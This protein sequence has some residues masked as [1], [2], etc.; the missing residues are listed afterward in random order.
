[1]DFRLVDLDPQQAAFAAEVA[2]FFARE[3]G[4]EALAHEHTTGDGFWEP[5][6]RAMGARG[7]IVD[8]WP[9]EEG[10]AGLDR[11]RHRILALAKEG[12]GLPFTTLDTTR[13]V[14]EAFAGFLAVAHLGAMGLDE[15][16][17]LAFIVDPVAERAADHPLLFVV[18]RV[19]RLHVEAELDGGCD[20]VDVLAAGAAGGDE[21]L[22]QF[23]FEIVQEDLGHFGGASAS[24]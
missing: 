18:E 1:M 23:V 22:L 19:R 8:T 7:W 21:L 11:L 14:A 20:L 13:L 10:G 3:A 16:D 4:P 15:E 9:R 12:C 6:H 24:C 5:L 17:K 2:E